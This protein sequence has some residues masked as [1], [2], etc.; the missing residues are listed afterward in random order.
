GAGDLPPRRRDQQPPRPAR[1]RLRPH[2]VRHI[3]LHCP[4]HVP[5]PPAAV[6][7]H[8]RP[9]RRSRKRLGVAPL[10]NVERRTLNAE[11]G[12]V[13]D[14]PSPHAGPTNIPPWLRSAV[15]RTIAITAVAL[16]P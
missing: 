2:H 4:R 7:I 13:C 6:Q 3:G 1:Y 9:H 12:P 16:D 15:P 11:V 10:A 8:L 14:W 5:L